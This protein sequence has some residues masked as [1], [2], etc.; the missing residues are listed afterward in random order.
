MPLNP[1]NKEKS[2]DELQEEDD[3]L[4]QE[5]SVQKKRQE[6]LKIKLAMQ[7]LDAR[8]GKGFW[9]RFSGDGTKKGFS[10]G[11]AISWLRNH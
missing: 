2:L 3:R 1:F 9:K 4:T 10:L 7:Q 5:L 6:L 11:G 8:G